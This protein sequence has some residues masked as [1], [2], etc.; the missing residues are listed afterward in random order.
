MPNPGQG[1]SPWQTWQPGTVIPAADPYRAPVDPLK[2]EDRDRTVGAIYRDI[3]AMSSL[4][5]WTWQTIQNVLSAHMLGIFNG[6]SMLFDTMQGDDRIQSALSQRTSALF[7]LPTVF[8]PADAD[9]SGEVLGAWKDAYARM[10]GTSATESILSE[11]KRVAIG[12]GLAV[13]EIQWDT[14]S[15][16]WRPILKPWPMQFVYFDWTARVL[17]AQTMD[18]VEPIVPGNGRWFV[19]APHGLYRGWLQGSVRA[20]A[21]P[22]IARNWSL[23]DWIRS[24]EVHGLPMRLADV[25]AMAQQADK[26]QFIS[27]LVNIGAEAVIGCPVNVDGTKF[28]VRLLEAHN[29]SWE[30]FRGLRNEANEAITLSILWQTATTTIPTGSFAAATVHADVKQTAID[31]DNTS[32]AHDLWQ[33]VA[34]PF[35][36]FNFG[37]ADLAPYTSHDVDP[38]EDRKMAADRLESFARAVAALKTASVEI[39]YAKLAKAYEIQ[40][41][42]ASVPHANLPPI[43]Q[44]HLTSPVVTINEARARLGLPPVDGGDQ[45][46]A[47]VAAHEA[48]PSPQVPA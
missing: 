48:A 23:R 27:S 43:Y 3:P 45:M 44:Y 20:L 16:P 28:D 9:T 39:D 5:G 7:G 6:S 37:N 32:L 34:R 14:S 24:S 12:M 42:E 8:D 18:S 35:A 26:G 10:G 36:A 1:G 21:T 46:V 31:F 30:V 25:P 33:Q 38:P 2:T 22:W 17:V 47:D 11:I 15:I 40:W 29:N 13:C 19:H 41:P 4:C